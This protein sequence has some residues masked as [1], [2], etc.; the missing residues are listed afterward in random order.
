MIGYQSHPLL[1][2]NSS[3]NISAEISDLVR[4]YVFEKFGW[5][6]TIKLVRHCKIEADE[7]KLKALTW[8]FM[9]G[10]LFLYILNSSISFLFELSAPTWL[11]VDSNLHV[12][13]IGLLA[14]RKR[15]VF[16]PSPILKY[17]TGGARMVKSCLKQ[18]KDKFNFDTL[19]IMALSVDGN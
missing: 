19:D 9:A 13:F 8:W 10:P 4:P 15:K 11:L 17:V 16:V 14:K 2:L 18:Y 12:S 6:S 7:W 5:L 1:E 3:N